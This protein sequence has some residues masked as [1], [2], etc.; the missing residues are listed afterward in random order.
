M[1][2]IFRQYFDKN[3]CT[4]TYLLGDLKNKIAILIDTVQECVSRDLKTIE[5]FKFDKVY[6]LST[7]VHADH[8]TG[9]ALIK[10][11]LGPNRS[12]S[13][14]SRYYDN[15][16]ADQL[17]GESDQLQHGCFK[18]N[19]L[20]TP[21][22]TAGCLCIVDHEHRR[23]FTG[24]TLLIRGCGRTD[25]QGGSS[26]KLYNSVHQKLFTLPAD[27][28]VYPAHDYNGITMS[29]IGEE[30]QLNSRLTKPLNEF[31]EI[32]SNLNLAYPKMIDVAVPRNLNC[33]Y[34]L[35]C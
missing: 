20:H 14:I 30:K 26:E 33:G 4:Y 23:V 32:M 15:V 25:F 7:H 27:Y 16:R 22:H 10:E 21:G 11:K 18:L 35:K 24:D 31:V 3:S 34:E 2:Q 9:N 19:F 17:V 8:V 1:N 13:I 12:M 28:A 5:E 6:L 29:S